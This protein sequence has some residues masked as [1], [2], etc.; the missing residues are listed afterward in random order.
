MIISTAEYISKTLS[1]IG[2]CVQ[3]TESMRKLQNCE[4]CGKE[5]CE[6]GPRLGKPTRIN[7]PL[8]E[9]AE[10][11]VAREWINKDFSQTTKALFYLGDCVRFTELMRRLPKCDSCGREGCEYRLEESTRINCPF[12]EE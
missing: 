3:F 12:G 7:C 10:E 6:Y 2:E 5:K 11:I 1:Y 4:S 9:E 8:W